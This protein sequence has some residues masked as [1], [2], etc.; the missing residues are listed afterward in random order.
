M[1]RIDDTRPFPDRP[2]P[3]RTQDWRKEPGETP[4]RTEAAP[5]EEAPLFVTPLPAPW[6]RVLPG[7]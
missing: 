2:S 1:I 6:P 5:D 7:L 4:D 3:G